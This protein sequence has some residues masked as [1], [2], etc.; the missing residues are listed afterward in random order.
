MDPD[1]YRSASI[2]NCVHYPDPYS[3]IKESSRYLI[4]PEEAMSEE[5]IDFINELDA[6]YGTSLEFSTC[7]CHIRNNQNTDPV[8]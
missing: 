1:P 6:Q 7:F 3:L 8:I 5:D 4:Y 2:K